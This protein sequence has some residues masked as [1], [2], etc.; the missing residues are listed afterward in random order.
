MDAVGRRFEGGVGKPVGIGHARAD[1]RIEILGREGFGA[2][3]A[4]IR[5][6]VH[7][8]SCAYAASDA[9]ERFAAVPVR[10]HPGKPF[11]ERF[12]DRFGFGLRGQDALYAGREGR[13]GPLADARVV[14][15]GSPDDA[16]EFGRSSSDVDERAALDRAV[17]RCSDEPQM[18]FVFG[19]EQ[20]Y[21]KPAARLDGAYGIGRVGAV[22]QYG[23]REYV[24]AL[25]VEVPEALGMP[26][27]HIERMGHARFGEHAAGDVR[28]EP[29]H[30]LVVQKRSEVFAGVGALGVVLDLVDAQA[31]RVRSQVDDSVVRHVAPRSS[32]GFG[33]VLP[34]IV[35][36]PCG[37]GRI[38]RPALP[39]FYSVL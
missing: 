26:G 21:G 2:H 11:L 15:I 1:D 29:R 16:G 38:A 37:R 12:F 5:L 6:G 22:T 7:L 4:A 35:A 25:A 33:A 28:R 10:V 9:V 19:G 17:A 30:H 3:A 34:F 39:L 36:L 27:E 18:G 8:R 31:D 20:R 23:G 32:L 13:K 14:V 24:G